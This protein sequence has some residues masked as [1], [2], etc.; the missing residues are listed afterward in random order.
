MIRVTSRVA[1]CVTGLLGALAVVA[2]GCATTAE[3][4]SSSYAPIGPLAENYRDTVKAD[5][6]KV[7]GDPEG[8]VYTFLPSPSQAF[9]GKRFAGIRYAWIVCGTVNVRNRTGDYTGP[10][11]FVSVISHNVVIDREVDSFRARDCLKEGG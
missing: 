1:I 11:P 4:A 7:D 5:L 8:A 2:G 9:I 10:K 6:A 3:S